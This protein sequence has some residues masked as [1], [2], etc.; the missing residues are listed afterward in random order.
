MPQR[1]SIDKIVES[2]FAVVTNEDFEY[3]G[4]IFTKR[5]LVVSTNIFRGFTCPIRCGGCC[6]RFSLDYLPIEERPYVMPARRIVFN[7]NEII[8][9][10]DLQEDNSNHHCKNLIMD[11]G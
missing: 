10:S 8:I 1:D 7:A 4:K 5:P 2:Y 6:P 9:H 11:T 3:K